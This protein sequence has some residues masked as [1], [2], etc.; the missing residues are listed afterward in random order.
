MKKKNKLK[1]KAYDKKP[2]EGTDQVLCDRL[3]GWLES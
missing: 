3:R 2:S 1:L